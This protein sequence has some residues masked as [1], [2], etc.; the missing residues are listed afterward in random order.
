MIHKEEPPAI[1]QPHLATQEHAAPTDPP[2]C[3]GPMVV[4][5][6]QTKTSGESVWSELHVRISCDLGHFAG[7][8]RKMPLKVACA[9]ESLAA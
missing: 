9:M 4:Q 6:V 7:S 1:R 5:I 3:R 2:I 8:K